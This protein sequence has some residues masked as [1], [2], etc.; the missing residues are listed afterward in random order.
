M[1]GP[2]L[3]K[4]PPPMA[5][6]PDMDEPPAPWSEEYLETVE[7]A[8]AQTADSGIPQRG[9]RGRRRRRGGASSRMDVSMRQ[10]LQ[11]T[12][13]PASPSKSVGGTPIRGGRRGELVTA[14][15]ATRANP[16]PLRRTLTS[17]TMATAPTRASSRAP[18]SRSGTSGS[19]AG[20]ARARPSRR[21]SLPQLT[22]GGRRLSFD[23]TVYEPAAV[24]S[25]MSSLKY[26]TTGEFD[27]AHANLNRHRG[28]GVAV[29][30]LDEDGQAE[31]LADPLPGPSVRM[32]GSSRPRR[33][34]SVDLD[35]RVQARR[36]A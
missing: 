10:T 5:P 18:G 17:A 31:A 19:G 36:S 20:A 22:L 26:M 25:P 3:A 6:A 27:M 15:A 16:S 24:Q 11:S 23:S 7:L 12:I 30:E 35:V 32:E 28:I 4:F 2:L 34:L 13:G 33:R 21:S 1:S 9:G 29:E 14:A 8:R